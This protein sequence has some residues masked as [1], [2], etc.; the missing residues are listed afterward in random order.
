M[1]IRHE[2][3]T[4]IQNI[5]AIHLQAFKGP[6]EGQIVK[7]LRTN[8]KLI[9]SLI[10]EIDKYPVGHIAYSPIYDKDTGIIGIGVGPVAVI[11]ARQKQGIGSRLIREGNKIAFYKGFDKIFVLGEPEYYGRFGFELAKQYNY[12]SGFDPEGTYFQIF[13]GQPEKAP[14]RIFVEYCQEFTET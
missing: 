14:G 6:V 8:H 9:I 12:Y 10:A 5:T 11:P 13:A 7:R 3:P 2:K 4:D 1:K